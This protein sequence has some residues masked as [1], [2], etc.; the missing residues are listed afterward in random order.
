[1]C[2]YNLFGQK[3]PP[4]HQFAILFWR[5]IRF[6]LSF[7]QDTT[8]ERGY[9]FG[10]LN[11]VGRSRMSPETHNRRSTLVVGAKTPAKALFEEHPLYYAPGATS[12]ANR[13]LPGVIIMRQ[14]GAEP[15]KGVGCHSKS[16]YVCLYSLFGQKCPPNHQFAILFWR[17]I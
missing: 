1:M 7:Q 15:T 9:I 12:P 10:Y 13:T 8:G 5:V 17:V 6:A 3:C 16:I 14:C 4:N 2:L 11:E